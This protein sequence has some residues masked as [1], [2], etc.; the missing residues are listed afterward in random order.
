MEDGTAAQSLPLSDAILKY[1]DPELLAAM[2]EAEAHLQSLFGKTGPQVAVAETSVRIAQNAFLHEVRWR[3][4]IGVI[5]LTGVQ[6][7]PELQ[8]VRSPIPGAWATAMEFDFAGRTVACFGHRWIA[9]TGS[10]CALDAP[11]KVAE[12]SYGAADAAVGT[13]PSE[14]REAT[15]AEP[16]ARSGGRPGFPMQEMVEIARQRGAREATNKATATALLRVFVERFPQRQPPSH[17]TVVDHVAEIYSEVQRVDR[18]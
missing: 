9:V 2:K 3:I 1:C 15:P 7:R 4:E 16:P 14:A 10:L 18:T 8:T 5:L 6:V 12:A 17:R 13:A 11:E